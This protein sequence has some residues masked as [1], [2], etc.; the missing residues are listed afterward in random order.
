VP[1]LLGGCLVIGAIQWWKLPNTD[2]DARSKIVSGRATPPEQST[3]VA[4]RKCTSRTA[5]PTP[6]PTG[7]TRPSTAVP[8]HPTPPI[9]HGS[10]SEVLISASRPAHPHSSPTTASGEV[11]EQSVSACEA[12]EYGDTEASSAEAASSWLP[13]S[14][15]IPSRAVARSHTAS[16]GSMSLNDTD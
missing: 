13:K 5:L 11:G 8:G 6:A 2:L 14:Q 12:T 10:T 9:P 16:R 7:P 3:N 15:S 1:K 4:S